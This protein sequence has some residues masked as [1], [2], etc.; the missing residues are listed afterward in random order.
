[1]AAIIKFMNYSAQ[2]LSIDYI[3][4][5]RAILI[6]YQTC[7]LCID[8]QMFS[9]SHLSLQ[10][11]SSSSKVKVSKLHKR[12]HQITALFMDMKHKETELAERRLKGLLT[13]ADTQAKYGW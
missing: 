2:L 10:P 12:K 13:K 6:S 5:E 1:M 4:I 7:S 8:F 3:K 9:C 11:E